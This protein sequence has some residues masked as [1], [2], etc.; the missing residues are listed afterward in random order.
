MK[1]LIKEL[2]D[3]VE[4]PIEGDPQ[5]VRRQ[6]LARFPWLARSGGAIQPLE[7]LLARLDRSQ[8]YTVRVLE[9]A[10]I[11]K[12]ERMADPFAAARWLTAAEA[13]DPAAK[14]LALWQADGDHTAAA[15]ALHGLEDTPANRGT[16][17]A[18]GKMQHQAPKE[19]EPVPQQQVEPLVEE[20]APA[21]ER[22]RRAFAAGQVRRA[23]IHGK[24]SAGSLLANDPQG[25]TL[26]LKPGVGVSPIQGE[27]E[28][29]ASQARREVAFWHVAQ[30]WGL[31]QWMPRAD[32]LRVG[33]QEMAAIEFLGPRWRLLGELEGESP[34]FS[35]RVLRKYLDGG[36]LHMWAALAYILGDGDQNSDNYMCDGE[37][38]QLIDH[39]SAFAG[40]SF[41]PPHDRV[42]YVPWPLR[43][44]GPKSFNMLPRHE[45]MRHMPR[46]PAADEQPLRAWL[47]GL[48]KDAGLRAMT[49]Y[50]VRPGPSLARLGKLQGMVGSELADL[51]VD[52]VWI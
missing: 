31:A 45:K 48:D 47:L 44:W 19:D 24:H 28:E 39:G 4:T 5:D 12:S 37:N 11:Q 38:V 20:A 1:V 46:L 10:P 35:S 7:Y 49:R 41:D 51:I 42:S 2:Y 32:L 50:G 23:D 15:L 26:L 16:I 33:D 52:S 8:G 34:G 9:A 14:R 3:Q 36:I 13:P 18:W 43:A 17:A 27:D 29:N 30:A 22:V 21:A 40:E 25:G 6:L